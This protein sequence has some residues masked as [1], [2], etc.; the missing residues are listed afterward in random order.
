MKHFLAAVAFLAGISSAH[1]ATVLGGQPSNAQTT[2]GALPLV[3]SPILNATSAYALSV[4]GVPLL[5]QSL[6][7]SNPTVNL[8][9][10]S[11][12]ALLP[13][14]TWSTLVGTNAG[15]L[16]IG[17]T[18]H[19]SAFG[20]QSGYNN[21]TGTYDAAFG[22]QAGYSWITDVNEVAVGTQNSKY[23]IYAGTGNNDSS[24]ALAMYSGGGFQNT[25]HGAYALY[26]NSGS[27]LL[28]GTATNNDTIKLVCTY[29]SYFSP[30]TIGP[31]T[32][33]TSETT[34][35]MAAA[36]VTAINNNGTFVQYGLGN[37]QQTNTGPLISLI[38]PGSSTQ[39]PYTPS[40]TPTITGSAT[41]TVTV[42]PGR[43]GQGNV[44]E[45]YEA[46][47]GTQMGAANYNE[48]IGVLSGQNV[49]SGSY[50]LFVGYN[51]GNGL[52]T[53]SG[54]VFLCPEGCTAPTA[55][56]SNAAYIWGNNASPTLTITGMNAPTSSLTTVAGALAIG[57]TK[58][59]TSGCSVSATTGRGGNAGSYTSGTS[60]TC[61]VVITIN[62]ATG[63]TTTN[64][65]YCGA[66]DLTTT[67]DVQ[68]QTASSATTC[69]ISGT[70]VS[71]DVVNFFAF[72]Y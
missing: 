38:F 71:G 15:H 1:A 63:I 21:S 20:A 48:G 7:S 34:T 22:D 64:G 40:C 39:G 27:I 65:W 44:A 43:N 56:T 55:A 72:P 31:I 29:N 28:G 51:S 5:T 45:G 58:F 59:T 11:G 67:A 66:N 41:E 19:F 13:K 24:G 70:T 23:S 35:Q 12:S 69:T 49:T 33:T 18:G 36:L 42:G 25:A 3:Q 37:L 62:G 9:Q 61:T 30:S 16:Y 46:L 54:N 14:S 32:I 10:G 8:G 2:P 52:T 47:Y 6:A 60:G 17:A 68:K 4:L 53:G 57:G 26:G 50:N